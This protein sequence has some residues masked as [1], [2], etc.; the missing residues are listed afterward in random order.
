MPLNML[1]EDELPSSFITSAISKYSIYA[2]DKLLIVTTSRQILV[3]KNQPAVPFLLVYHYA[4]SHNYL[5]ILLSF[6]VTAASTTIG[7]NS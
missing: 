7:D 3:S 1:A 5:G 4:K 6:A 2:L